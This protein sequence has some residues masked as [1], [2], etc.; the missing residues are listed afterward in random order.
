MRPATVCCQ[1]RFYRCGK[2]SFGLFWIHGTACVCAQPPRNGM[3]Q[4]GTGLLKKE[5]MVL[6]E[7]VRFGPSIPVET[8]KAC[9]LIVLH[10]MIEENSGVA[11]LGRQVARVKATWRMTRCSSSGY[12]DP[13]TAWFSKVFAIH[14]TKNCEGTFAQL[15][16]WPFLLAEKGA[17]T[18]LW[19]RRFLN[20]N[21]WSAA[22]CIRGTDRRKRA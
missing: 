7:L 1:V 21:K 13:V 8:V 22:S 2:R 10:M 20:H 18:F 9:A 16:C 11:L 14:T 5:P 3:S 4:G 15:S 6:R 17:N 19:S 12:M